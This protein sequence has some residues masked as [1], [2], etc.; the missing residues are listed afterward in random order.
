MSTK[1]SPMIA[2]YQRFR[3]F[4]RSLNPGDTSVRGTG[5]SRCRTG[6]TVLA[7]RSVVDAWWTPLVAMSGGSM[8][9]QSRTY[10]LDKARDLASARFAPRVVSMSPYDVAVDDF[11][12]RYAST[13][14]SFDSTAAAN[15]W[16]TPGMILDDRSAGVIEDRETMAQGLER[17]YNL[18]RELGLAA[19]GHECL[20][21]DPLTDVIKL[22]HV[23]WHFY[24]ADGNELTDSNAHYI[25][26]RDNDRL[27]ACVCIQVDDAEK[28]QAL[29]TERGIDLSDGSR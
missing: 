4:W 21:V 9:V 7:G 3:V 6:T 10:F 1:Q 18:Y 27:Y 8:A 23:R 19:V 11:L 22:V 28:I 5:L 13:L 14:T 26:R 15:L 2:K 24:D 17:A 16:A 12:T 20:K 25:V 29:A